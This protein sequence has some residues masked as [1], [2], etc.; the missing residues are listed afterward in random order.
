MTVA[1]PKVVTFIVGN[2][3]DAD[4]PVGVMITFIVNVPVNPFKLAACTETV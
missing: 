3:A 1:F 4:G 2:A